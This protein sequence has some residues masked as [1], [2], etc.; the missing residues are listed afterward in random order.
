MASTKTLT[1]TRGI[2]V[3][4]SSVT[5]LMVRKVYRTGH[6]I[7]ATDGYRTID[8]V[9]FSDPEQAEAEANRLAERTG[10]ALGEPRISVNEG[11]AKGRYAHELAGNYRED[12]LPLPLG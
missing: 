10:L 7:S 5:H 8:L 6:T 11:L 9:T 3:R 1:T 12:Q 4:T 2:Q